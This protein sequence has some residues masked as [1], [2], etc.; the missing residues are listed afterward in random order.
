M[1]LTYR[2]KLHAPYFISLLTLLGQISRP[3]FGLLMEPRLLTL[4]LITTLALL[5]G[6]I[7]VSCL[8]IMF[9]GL[10]DILINTQALLIYLL[11]SP[12]PNLGSIIF[13]QCSSNFQAVLLL[14]LSVQ[15]MCKQV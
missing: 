11:P 3:A 7:F 14:L 1:L 12:L 13:R 5:V 10:L 4:N 6:T 2:V 15:F 9:L 8:M